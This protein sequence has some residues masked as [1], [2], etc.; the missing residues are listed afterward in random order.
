MALGRARVYRNISATRTED[1][2]PNA[3]LTQIVRKTKFAEGINVKTLA[4]DYVAKM[5][6]ARQLIM[7]QCV[8]ARMDILEIRSDIVQLSRRNVIILNFFF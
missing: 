3:S 4:R 5:P 8:R 1:V 7:Y 2:C 6:N